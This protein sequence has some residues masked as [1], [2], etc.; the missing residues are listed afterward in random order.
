MSAQDL[1]NRPLVMQDK[2]EKL[3]RQQI[4]RA[5]QDI[6]NSHPLR[7]TVEWRHVSR[8][9]RFCC[10]DKKNKKKEF[11]SKLRFCIY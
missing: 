8:T 9:T 11:L 4:N 1:E 2:G 5:I 6:D 3:N 10:K 7:N